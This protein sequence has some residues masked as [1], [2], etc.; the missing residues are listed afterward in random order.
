MM[1]VTFTAD[2]LRAARERAGLTRAQAAHRGECSLSTIANAEDGAMPRR[3]AALARVWA[4]LAEAG[5]GKEKA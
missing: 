4:A 5:G 3:S 2:E 1:T